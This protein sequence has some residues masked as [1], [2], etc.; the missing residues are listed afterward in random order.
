MRPKAILQLLTPHRSRP[1]SF[2][3]AAH[4]TGSIFTSCERTAPASSGQTQSRTERSFTTSISKARLIT[5]RNF[6]S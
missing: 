3:H 6:A 2:R 5:L 4:R 1:P